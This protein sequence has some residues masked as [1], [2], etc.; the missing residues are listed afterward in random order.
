M[1]RLGA[2]RGSVS[3]GARTLGK[4]NGVDGHGRCGSRLLV[5]KMRD[6]TADDFA[7]FIIRPA[8]WGVR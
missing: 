1:H 6:A 8:V 5:S 2:D 4:H 7:A 3:S